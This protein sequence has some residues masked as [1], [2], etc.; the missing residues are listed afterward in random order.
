MKK[1]RGCLNVENKS[2]LEKPTQTGFFGFKR[3]KKKDPSLRN[4]F[5]TNKGNSPRE[6]KIILYKNWYK[7]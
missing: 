2:K 1:S 7:F 6:I 3:E 5:L 4:Y